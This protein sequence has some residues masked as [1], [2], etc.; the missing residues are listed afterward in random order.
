[1][2]KELEEPLR[3]CCSLLVPY[4]CALVVL[5]NPTASLGA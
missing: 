1:M 4:D 2:G 3:C 5:S